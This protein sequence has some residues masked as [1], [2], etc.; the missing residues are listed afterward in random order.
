MQILTRFARDAYAFG[1]ILLLV[2][3][4]PAVAD[5]YGSG[6]LS[7]DTATQPDPGFNS[8]STLATGI[9]SV[10]YNPAALM[11]GG[12]AEVSLAFDYPLKGSAASHAYPFKIT[13]QK[14]T[15]EANIIAG[16][17]FTDDLSD[18]TTFK[19]RE[20]SAMVS[21]SRGGGIT[22]FGTAFRFTDFFAFGISRNREAA[23]GINA[24]GYHPTI[25]KATVNLRGM[26]LRD[27]GNGVII[28]DD[29]YLEFYQGGFV[30]TSDAQVWNDFLSQEAVQYL[31]NNVNLETAVS[32]SNDFVI[33]TASKFG[34][35]AM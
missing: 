27:S 29:G 7:F 13:D 31:K 4:A 9:N 6:G 34:P 3:S 24:Q 8:F 23:F 14:I 16:V 28:R 17:Y 18:T 26:D 19:T 30:T 10:L 15:E 1:V 32:G 33:T 5:T 22:S 25:A 2:I 12:T 35:V 11:R 21:S 20:A